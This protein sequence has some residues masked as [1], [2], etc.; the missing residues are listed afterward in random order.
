MLACPPSWAKEGMI[1]LHLSIL[2]CITADTYV[3]HLCV[4]TSVEQRL[5]YSNVILILHMEMWTCIIT[6]NVHSIL[7][8]IKK[9][10]VNKSEFKEQCKNCTW[11]FWFDVSSDYFCSVSALKAGD[12]MLSAVPAARLPCAKDGRVEGA[13]SPGGDCFGPLKKEDMAL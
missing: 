8:I 5:N 11:V 9:K 2:I 10:C 6:W 1:I 4:I 12:R 13:A 3:Y 7:I